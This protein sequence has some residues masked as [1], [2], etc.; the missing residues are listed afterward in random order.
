MTDYVALIEEDAI[1]ATANGAKRSPYAN[2][3]EAEENDKRVRLQ[4]NILGAVGNDPDQFAKAKRIELMTGIPADVANRNF[5]EAGRKAQLLSI[6]ETLAIHPALRDKFTGDSHFA[7]LAHDDVDNL[8]LVERTARQ[9]VGS[10]AENVGRSLHGLGELANVAQRRA[11][12]AFADVFLPAP[13]AGGKPTEES[14]A[15]P[16][17]GQDARDIGKSTMNH[18]RRE[19]LLPADKQTFADQVVGGL[20][21]VASQIVMLPIDRGASLFAQGASVMSEKVENDDA[22]QWKKDLAIVGGSAVTGITEKYALDKLLAPLPAAV[23]NRL[24]AALGRI[25]V[26]GIAEGGQEITESIAHDALRILLTNQ[27]AKIEVGQAM[28]EGAVG[29]TVGAIVRSVVESALH[30]K[31]RGSRSSTPAEKAQET[32]AKLTEIIDAAASSKLIARESESVRGL[33]EATAG[34]G[35][36]VFLDGRKLAQTFA[37]SGVKLD[38]VLPSVASQIAVAAET[39][40]DVVV[41]VGELAIAIAQNEALRP[42]IEHARTDPHDPTPA[43]AQA[44]QEQNGEAFQQEAQLAVNLTA[45]PDEIDSN[46]VQQVFEKVLGQL[47]EAGRFTPAVNKQYAALT[48]DVF[49]TI[50]QRTGTDMQALVDRYM[51]RI[52]NQGVGSKSYAQPPLQPPEGSTLL[53]SDTVPLPTAGKGRQRG[54]FDPATRT[55]AL[56]DGADLTSFLH[57]SGH[58]YLEVLFDIATQKDAPVQIAGDTQR[59]LAWFGVPDLQTWQAMDMEAKRPHHEA[60]ARG[61]EAYL[62]EGNSPS[63]E[64]QSTFSRFRSWLV[65]VYKSL[66][67]LDVE[68]TDEVRAVFDRLI[69]TDQQINNAQQI[70]NAHP[71]YRTKP[72][73][74]S[75]VEWL[76]Y[77]SM[78]EDTQNQ[79]LAAFQAKRLKDIAHRRTRDGKQAYKSVRQ[80]VAAEVMK[81]PV[82]AVRQYLTSGTLP[83]GTKAGD[84]VKLD[85]PTLKAIYGEGPDALW[86]SLPFGQYGM[87][88]AQNGVHPDV[89]AEQFGFRSGDAMLH[90][91]LAAPKAEQVIKAEAEQRFAEQFG[92]AFTAEAITR[93]AENELANESRS[94]QLV[95]ELNVLRRSTGQGSVIHKATKEYADKMIGQLPVR[96][97]RNA[98]PHVAAEARAGKLAEHAFATGDLRTAASAK[99]D[100]VLNH[101]LARKAAEAKQ[102]IAAFFDRTRQLFNK[103]ATLAKTR[104]MDLVNASRAILAAHGLGTSDRPAMAY[105]EQIRKNDPETYADIEPMIHEALL[106]QKDYRAMTMGEFR[107]MADTVESLWHLSRR[108]R[109]IEIDGQLLDRE[110]VAQQLASA[111]RKRGQPYAELGQHQ[112]P[113]KKDQATFTFLGIRAALRRV[114]SW[115]TSIDG[116]KSGAVRTYLW[117]PIAE[118]ANR[119]RDAK[120]VHLQKYLNI[121]KGVEKTLTNG[122]IEAPEI[123]YTFKDKA[124]LLHAILH[125]GNDSNLRK[126]LLGRNWGEIREDGSA[127]PARWQAFI[128]RAAAEGIVSKADFE[129]AQGVWDLLEAMKPAAQETHRGMYGFYFSE[130]T[131]SPV[132]TPFG[133]FRGGYVP[134]IADP[135]IVT[136]AAVHREAEA[137]NQGNVG[138]FPSTGRGFTKGRVDYNKPLLLDLSFLPSHIDKVLKFTHIEPRVKDAARIVKNS[139]TFGPA[140]DALDPTAR[141][142]LLLPWLQR[143]ASQRVDTPSQGRAGRA[144]DTFFREL[145]KRSG[146]QIMTANVVNAM[147]Q[148]TGLSSAMVKVAPRYMRNALWQYTKQPSATAEA[149][150]EKSAFMRNRITSSTIEVQQ[151]IDELL[152]NPTKYEK[153]RAFASKHGYFL[154][155]GFQ[156]VVDVVTWQAAYEQATEKGEREG[157]AIRLAD[158]AV[159]ETQ[160]SFAPE[161]MS[162]FESGTPFVRA[163][164]MFYSYFNTNA[165]LLG[166][167]FANTHRDMGLREGAGRA[168]YLYTFG[169]MIPAV[170]AEAIVRAMGQGFDDDKDGDV[171]LWEVFAMFFGAQGRFITGM[172]PGVGPAVMAGANAFNNK[173]YDDRISTSPAVSM[174]ESSV[175]APHS[176]YKAIADNGSHKQ[177]IRD[178]LTAVGMLTGLPVAPV[179]R[180]LGYLA[181]IEQGKAQPDGAGDVVRGLIT[182]RQPKD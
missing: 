32:H 49:A 95:A 122:K 181:D 82:Y 133:T 72:D 80:Q 14:L 19:V 85:L 175:R 99:R 114:E 45:N 63:I 142:D 61:F 170:L 22:P 68:L 98:M 97:A 153:A 143:T 179:G 167:E 172:I 119:Y 134:A 135:S 169:F 157:E 54:S 84:A 155:S 8:S 113:T 117:N 86:R 129:F 69:A 160:G 121:V 138:M 182:G 115:A 106:E 7:A 127:N 51:P 124:E 173:W 151:T 77:Q 148:I 21:Q 5:A 102:E 162:R 174:I 125:T 70:R 53:T 46:A 37:Q 78:G 110:D 31:S 25:V 58:F 163:F 76:A 17:V 103:D 44:W 90:E 130:I 96:R 150:S 73:S 66:S 126:L 48:R 74:M 81:R 38:A 149:I 79:A 104:D 128:R 60:F 164:T 71:L 131:A 176:I 33:I 137:I 100:Q 165:N 15:G 55:I 136:D 159:R 18:Y 83:D 171:E 62:F 42:L 2:L 145:R 92:D 27:D 75:E 12:S 93:S 91:I 20:G 1:G 101:Q 10:A 141:T 59:L 43:E 65:R 94:Q 64:L 105:V 6:N 112:A 40:S 34:E 56:L 144:A 111:L 36:E 156:N 120:R 67:A 87:A 147:Q 50:S 152:L 47:N 154:Q 57:E 23:K 161:D 41:P 4:Q 52:V 166:S 28:Q 3:I 118:A 35:A 140:M 39:G 178:T 132:V 107:A 146:L 109:Q 168:L 29:F 11:L 177:A 26:G 89:I 13:M 30:I 180:P 24:G 139:K 158:S 108:T 123:G 116:G 88:S 16:L 9:F